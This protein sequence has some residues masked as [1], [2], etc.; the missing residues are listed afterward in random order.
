M[1][2]DYS[3]LH[4][5]TT[6]IFLTLCLII[7]GTYQEETV[8]DIYYVAGFTQFGILLL[9]CDKYSSREVLARYMEYFFRVWPFDYIKN[10]P[11]KYHKLMGWAAVIFSLFFMLSGA[12][13]AATAHNLEGTPFPAA[14]FIVANLWSCMILLLLL[15]GAPRNDP[16]T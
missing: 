8:E 9:F 2:E 11:D 3:S 16:P 1:A 4:V 7:F 5:F 10:P 6:T 12:K 14:D 13:A 15:L